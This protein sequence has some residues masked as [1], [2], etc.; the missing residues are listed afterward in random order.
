MEIQKKVDS[1]TQTIN[2]GTG[3]LVSHNTAK[4][5]Q[6]YLITAKHVL[7]SIL[8][9]PHNFSFKIDTASNLGYSVA[10]FVPTTSETK[11]SITSSVGIKT[12][13][14]AWFMHHDFDVSAIDISKTKFP[15]DSQAA[16]FDISLLAT[17]QTFASLD[18]AATD[19]TFVIVYDASLGIRLVR[20]GMIA[21]MSNNGT[22]LME[23]RN[24]QG[25]SG[26]PVILQ[27]TISRK[28]GVIAPTPPTIIGLQSDIYSRLVPIG[29]FGNTQTDLMFPEAAG[30]S[31]VQPSFRILEIFPPQ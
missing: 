1:Q 3:F 23:S 16:F 2:I 13:E 18:L 17:E 7:A 21:A 10:I 5:E 6:R 8:P 29:K 25:D 27:P 12:G 11:G 4:G 15:K 22:F 26:S 20:S 31:L 19:Q 30:L 9:E 28:F 14:S 24:L